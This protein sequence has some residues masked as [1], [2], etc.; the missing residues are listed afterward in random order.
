[1]PRNPAGGRMKNALKVGSKVV[2]KDST[3]LVYCL[4]E[5]GAGEL[6]TLRVS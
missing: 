1:M 3:N 6:E 4:R 2:S 5:G